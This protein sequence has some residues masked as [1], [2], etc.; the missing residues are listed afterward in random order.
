MI[1]QLFI[2]IILSFLFLT[3]CSEDKKTVSIIVG[4]DTYNVEIAIS[5]KEQSLG[6]MNRNELQADEGM[7]FTYREDRKLSFWMKDTFVPLSIAFIAK[8]GTIKEIYNIIYKK[9]VLI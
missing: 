2:I 8:D 9:P 5:R 7:I 6:L 3:A 1:K 4:S